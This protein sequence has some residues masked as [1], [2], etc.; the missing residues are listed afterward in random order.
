MKIKV[1]CTCGNHLLCT[2]I[3]E[4]IFVEPCERCLKKKYKLGFDK[5]F[6]RGCDKRDPKNIIW[7]SYEIEEKE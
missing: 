2:I 1:L 4:Q 3:G 5:G 6:I 7:E